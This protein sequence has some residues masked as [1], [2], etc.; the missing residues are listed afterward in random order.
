VAVAVALEVTLVV[1]TGPTQK[2]VVLEEVL[3]RIVQYNKVQQL[4][5]L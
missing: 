1:E 2:M 5:E 3:V 4:L